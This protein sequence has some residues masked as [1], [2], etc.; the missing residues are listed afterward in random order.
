MNEHLRDRILRKLDSLN[1]ERGYQVLDYVEFLESRYAEKSTTASAFTRFSE[2]VED[3]LRAGKVS[4]TTI[5]E[6]MN[7]MLMNRAAN[8]L[9]GAVAAG[10]S[11]ANDLVTAARSTGESAAQSARPSTPGTAQSSAG[12]PPQPDGASSSA[13]AAPEA[14]SPARDTKEPGSGEEKL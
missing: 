4:A 1:D 11:M 12:Q 10:K 7:L 2:A 13:G 9:N 6:A 14:S 3:R 8:V 5:A